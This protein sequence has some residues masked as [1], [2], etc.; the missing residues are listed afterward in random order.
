MPFVVL[1]NM[2]KLNLQNNIAA[3][4]IE[5]FQKLTWKAQSLWNKT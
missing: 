3:V 5:E 4:I 1:N 2:K